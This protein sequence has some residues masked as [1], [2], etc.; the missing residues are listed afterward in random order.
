MNINLVTTIDQYLMSNKVIQTLDL[1][2]VELL[3]KFLYNIISSDLDKNTLHNILSYCTKVFKGKMSFTKDLA[4]FSERAF[5]L[6]LSSQR[7]SRIYQ[8]LV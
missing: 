4:T 8:S 5:N 6:I 2:D 1:G 7:R 3:R